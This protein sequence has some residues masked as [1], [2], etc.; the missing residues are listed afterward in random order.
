VDLVDTVV[1][2]E[3]LTADAAACA[4]LAELWLSPWAYAT[5]VADRR[6]A[7]PVA[8]MNP[9]VCLFTRIASESVLRPPLVG[10]RRTSPVHPEAGEL[11]TASVVHPRLW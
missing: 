3:A 8:A 6:S 1:E 10:A 9:L 5:V 7:D 4:P 11:A 2:D